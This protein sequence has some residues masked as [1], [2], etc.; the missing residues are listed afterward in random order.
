MAGEIKKYPLA[1]VDYAE[2]RRAKDL[3]AIEELEGEVVLAVAAWLGET[4]LIDHAVV[5]VG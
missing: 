3:A 4:R 2:V 5:E 1:R